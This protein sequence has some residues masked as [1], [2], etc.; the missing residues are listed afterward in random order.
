[1][2]P[3]EFVELYVAYSA[4]YCDGAEPTISS[5]EDFERKELANY[6]KKAF[7]STN[8]ENHRDY[9]DYNDIAADDDDDDLME[10]YVC[11]TPTVRI[12][13]LL[14]YSFYLHSTAGRTAGLRLVVFN[15]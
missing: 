10:A 3:R 15:E 6:K 14:N 5:L 8:S 13:C 9:D 12:N 4:T 11:N 7:E 1:M 2:D